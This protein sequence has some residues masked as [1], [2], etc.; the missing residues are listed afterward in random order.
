MAQIKTCGVKEHLNP[1]KVSMFEGRL[2][3]T[4]TDLV[5]SQFER[6]QR[7]LVLAGADLE[8]T[9]TE[10]PKRN[11]SLRVRPNGRGH[12][13]MQSRGLMAQQSPREKRIRKS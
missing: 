3:E 6:A 8:V 12:A 7:K 1:I 10:T 11:W 4:R 2:V 5:R 13:R 9:I